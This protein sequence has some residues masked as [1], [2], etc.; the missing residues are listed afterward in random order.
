MCEAR[1]RESTVSWARGM[2]LGAAVEAYI[3]VAT[4]T[5]ES[6]LFWCYCCFE[7]TALLKSLRARGDR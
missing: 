2:R 1:R 6:G 3:V 5:S 4:S 7:R